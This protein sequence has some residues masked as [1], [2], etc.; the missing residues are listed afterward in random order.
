MVG[1]ILQLDSTTLPTLRGFCGNE[2]D[3]E[4]VIELCSQVG[5]RLCDVFLAGG[6]ENVST[7]LVRDLLECLPAFIVTGGTAEI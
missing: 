1:S 6:C 7:R 5:E 4:H 2:R 3:I